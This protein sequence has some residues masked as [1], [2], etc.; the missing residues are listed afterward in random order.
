MKRFAP[1][2]AVAVGSLLMA[3]CQSEAARKGD[4]CAQWSVARY[5]N[6]AFIEPA[7]ETWKALG[8]ERKYPSPIEGAPLKEQHHLNAAESLDDFCEFY[9]P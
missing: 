9:K 7:K 4:I 8:I 2:A 1:I 3:S 5:E 6:E